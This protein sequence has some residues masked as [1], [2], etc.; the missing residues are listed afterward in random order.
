MS[1]VL[2]II[3]EYNPFHNG[4]LHHLIESKKISTVHLDKIFRQAAK[5]KIIVN[6][7]RVNNGKNFINKDDPELEEDSKQDFFF[8]VFK[9]SKS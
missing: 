1:N 8:R 6:A 5:S 2:G 3:A 9:K 4:H 7:H